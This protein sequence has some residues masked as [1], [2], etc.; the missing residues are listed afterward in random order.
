MKRLNKTQN[1]IQGIIWGLV[2][3]TVALI[4]PFIIRTILI[5]ELGAE[6]A[7]LNS[8]FTSI[9]QVISLA[10]LGVG[11]AIVFSMYRAVSEDNKK[12]L[13]AYL[14]YF[15]RVFFL[16]GSIIVM[17]GLLIMPFLKYLIKGS[18]PPDINIYIL[19][20]IYLLNTSISY[21]VFAYRSSIL[22]AYQREADNYKFQTVCSSIM[23]SVQI[24]VLLLFENYY[25]YI[26]FLPIFTFLLNISRY[27]YIQKK[28]P[29]IKC[30]GLLPKEQQK[31][32]KDNVFALFLHKVGSVTVNTLDNIVISSFLGLVILSNYNNYYYL[33]SAVTAIVLI[34]FSSLTAG[35]GNS[36]ITE[37]REK[38]KRDFY[39]I[40][41]LN[42]FLVVVSTVCFFNMYQDFIMLWVGEKYLFNDSTMILFCIYYYIHTIR[43]TIICYR[44]AAGMWQDNKLQP[45]VSSIFNLTLNVV[46]V[47][48]SGINGVIASTIISM[49]FIDIPWETGKLIKNLFNEPVTKYMFRLMHYSFISVFCCYLVHLVMEFIYIRH[50]IFR[51]TVEFVLSVLTSVVFFAFLT[52][53]MEELKNLKII[54]KKVIRKH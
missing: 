16:I 40:F 33:I 2:N 12:M 14:N 29:D 20:M 1:T 44:D 49:I 42:G 3:K 45:I 32:I 28:Y 54:I 48:K 11:S 46:L 19:Y 10:D 30:E 51:L 34:L 13:S 9:L 4:F 18:I 6:Y 21:F 25:I 37:S 31:E 41:Y 52:F 35:L 36:I 24:I 5:W 17:I 26:L 53:R 7:G 38:V 27:L 50:I 39:T 23:Y 43:R 15:R 47:Q 22:S 8:L